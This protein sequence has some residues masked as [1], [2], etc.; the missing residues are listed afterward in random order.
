MSS[1]RKGQ[2]RAQRGKVTL[3]ARSR[4]TRSVARYPGL[5]EL[6]TFRTLPIVPILLTPVSQPRTQPHQGLLALNTLRE[7]GN[8]LSYSCFLLKRDDASRL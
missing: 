2:G 4:F 5:S 3:G 8:G 7:R 1:D 6:M